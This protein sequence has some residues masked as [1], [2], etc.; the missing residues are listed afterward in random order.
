MNGDGIL[1]RLFL[2]L[3]LSFTHSYSHCNTIICYLFQKPLHVKGASQLQI[4]VEIQYNPDENFQK[5]FFFSQNKLI[6][7]VI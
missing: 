7:K 6:L 4:D 1:A 3:L 2:F 5:S